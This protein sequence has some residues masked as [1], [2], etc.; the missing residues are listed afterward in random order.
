MYREKWKINGVHFVKFKNQEGQE[1]SGYQ[2]YFNR[3]P[4]DDVE[5][6]RWVFGGA[7]PNKP[8]WID[9]AKKVKL[10]QCLTAGNSD[11]VFAVYEPAGRFNRLSTFEVY[12]EDDE[13]DIADIVG[14]ASD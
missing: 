12:D 11:C 3:D 10:L 5:R 6:V 14:G 9:E 13:I 7:C 1:V 2:V 4:Y 8:Q